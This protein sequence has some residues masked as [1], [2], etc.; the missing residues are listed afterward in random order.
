MKRLN[1]RETGRG[2]GGDRLTNIPLTPPCQEGMMKLTSWPG[3]AENTPG[4]GATC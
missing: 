4:R 3:G 2:D 1:N